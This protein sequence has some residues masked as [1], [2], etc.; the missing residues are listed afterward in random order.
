[1]KRMNK[2]LK[3]K[4]EK[5]RREALHRILDLVLDINGMQESKRKLTGSH[6]TVFGHISGH[7][8]AFEI[9]IHENGWEPDC[10]ADREFFCYFDNR[11]IGN[12]PIQMT[13]ELEKY[14]EELGV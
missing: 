3:K 1:M 6:P 8:A 9:D 12:N 13:E 11:G 10:G 5:M 14:K 4:S 2:R 7:I